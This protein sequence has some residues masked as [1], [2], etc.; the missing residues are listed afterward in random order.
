MR[1]QTHN[2]T[3]K[4]ISDFKRDFMKKFIP[5]LLIVFLFSCGK[6]EMIS[7]NIKKQRYEKPS[8]KVSEVEFEFSSKKNNIDL[9]DWTY[10]IMVKERGMDYV[11]V[12]SSNSERWFGFIKNDE[13][14]KLILRETKDPKFDSVLERKEN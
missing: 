13:D 12:Y 6:E 4:N 11:Y 10:R 3:T 7:E 9:G 2:L 1:G 5:L 14:G 8:H